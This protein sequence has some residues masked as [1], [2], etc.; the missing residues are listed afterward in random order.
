[1]RLF[2]A[3]GTGRFSWSRSILPIGSSSCSAATVVGNQAMAKLAWARTLVVVA[4]K[5]TVRGWSFRRGS[6]LTGTTT[7]RHPAHAHAHRVI[8]GCAQISVL[9][10][11]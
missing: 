4:G 10:A 6:L 9:E 7:Q 1:V 8:A 5:V 3:S 11:G 2:V